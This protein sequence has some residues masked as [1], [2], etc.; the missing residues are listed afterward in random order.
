MSA[1]SYPEVHRQSALRR[2][3]TNKLHISAL[4]VFL[5]FV[6][7]VAYIISGVLGTPLTSRPKSVNVD[8]PAT[9]GL[10][11]GSSV[12]YRG[13]RVGRVTS[14]DFTADGVR[15]VAQL[16]SSKQIPKDSRAVV[17]SLSPV[18]EQYLDFQPRSDKGPYLQD[19]STIKAKDTRI[20]QSLASTVISV[21]KLLNQIDPKDLHTVLDEASKAFAGTSTDLGRLTDQGQAIIH[22]LN[23]YWPNASRLATNAGTLLDIGIRNQAKIA[24]AAHDF[25]VFARF[26]KDYDPELLRTLQGSPADIRQLRSLV[27][28]ADDVLPTFLRLGGDVSALLGAYTP[29]LRVLLS[30]FA[31]GLGVLGKAVRDGSLQLT[32]IGQPDHYCDYDTTRLDPK[33]PTNRPLQKNGHCPGSFTW[34]QRGAAHAPGPVR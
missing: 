12:T 33:K 27:K 30:Q 13:V 28:D 9:G 15:A 4:G 21:N 18:G 20:P 23:K 8:L 24:R 19:G 7:C 3:L 11:V 31:P 25:A 32:I 16:N 14:I 10:F 6:L 26:L 34:D 1:S 29:H 17:R 2:A 5:V 22:D